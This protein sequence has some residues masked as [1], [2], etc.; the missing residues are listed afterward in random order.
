MRT[1]YRRFQQKASGDDG[2]IS[3]SG[4]IVERAF[5]F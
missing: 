3:S 4:L 5:A 2:Q 1:S